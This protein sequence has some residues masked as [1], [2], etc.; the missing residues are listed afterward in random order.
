MKKITQTAE[1]GGARLDFDDFRDVFND[2]IWDAMEASYEQFDSDTEGIIVSGCAVSGS[3]GNYT[4]AAGIVYI[5]GEFRRFSQQ[6]G[7]TFPQYMKA[8]TDVNTT[9]T[10]GDSTTKT[11]FITKSADLQSTVPGSGQY[12]SFT[13]D[14][15]SSNARRVDSGWKTITLNASGGASYAAGSRTPQYRVKAGIVHLRGI[16]TTGGSPPAGD[17]AVSGS[18]ALPIPGQRN[19]F[20]GINSTLAAIAT[21]YVDTT[22]TLRA[23]SSSSWGGTIILDGLQYIL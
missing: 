21:C 18:G 15:S 22:G 19:D 12:I 23:N 2:E 8:A 5:D 13:G 4:I 1:T 3:A 7:L 9:R 17:H 14:G 16:I 10:F 6:T 11:L 20:L